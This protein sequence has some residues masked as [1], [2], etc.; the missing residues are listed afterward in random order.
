MK[1]I[2]FKEPLFHAIVEG[3]KTQTRRI[4][5]DSH[6][7]SDGVV[8]HAYEDGSV[9]FFK[10][11]F[12]LGIRKPRYTVG[13]TLY[14]KEPY[15]QDCHELEHSL[16]TE[17][18]ANGKCLYR[19][20]GDVITVDDKDSPFGAWKNKLFMPERWARY[21]IKVTAVR[22]E[23]LQDI[24]EED[25]FKEG[26]VKDVFHLPHMYGLKMNERYVSV[27]KDSARKAYAALIDKINGN[28]TWDSNPWVWVYDFELV[29]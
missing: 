14:L 8:A 12:L 20:A 11:G 4:V 5:V 28:G 24:S 9:G 15:L 27:Y 18:I 29:K 23:R 1:G 6:K 16:G 21:F 22:C 7:L 19:Y 17:R 3:R 25:C 10:D 2:C 26:I 13:E